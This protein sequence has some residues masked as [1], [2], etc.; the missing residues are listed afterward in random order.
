[1]CEFFRFP[2]AQITGS[3]YRHPQYQQVHK[4]LWIQTAIDSLFT[5][6]LCLVSNTVS[7]MQSQK[8]TAIK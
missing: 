7:D 5:E 2:Y 6:D 8:G 3:K 4:T 1:M